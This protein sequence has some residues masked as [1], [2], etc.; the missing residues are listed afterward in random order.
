MITH[1]Y[2]GK[3]GEQ[4]VLRIRGNNSMLCSKPD[5]SNVVLTQNQVDQTRRFSGSV[6]VSI[7][8][9]ADVE[10]ETGACTFDSENMN[11]V[12]TAT[13]LQSP[14]A[15]LKVIAIVRDMPGHV[16]EKSLT[17]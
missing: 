11:W 16:V 17:L 2:H 13:T 7:R 12:Y 8:S 5:R 10:L 15:G 14:I 6:N 9:S 4:F 1:G 3:A